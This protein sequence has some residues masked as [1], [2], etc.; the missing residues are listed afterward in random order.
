MTPKPPAPPDPKT[1]AAA[2]TATN[3]STAVAN[4]ALGNVNQ[5]TPDGSLTYSKTGLEKITDPNT[6]AT[7][8]VPIYTAT[9]TYSPEQQAIYEQGK[10]AELGLATTAADQ[11]EFLQDYLGEPIKIDNEETESRLFDLGRQRLDPVL[12][13]RQT[14]LETQLSN[15]GV[16]RGSEAFDRAMRDNAQFS[17]DAYNQLLLSGRSQAVQEQLAERSAPINEITALLSGSQVSQ[18]QFVNTSMPQIPTVDYAGLVNQN[19]AQQMANYQQQA[20]GRNSLVGGLFSL[21]GTLGRA[22]IGMP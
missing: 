9:Q 17:N 15:Q 22:A 16:K 12:S 21:G 1:T 18:P 2:Q 13:E 3:V 5:I 19:Y 14:A 6:G 8:D 7:Y 20:A 11:A 4:A 10:R